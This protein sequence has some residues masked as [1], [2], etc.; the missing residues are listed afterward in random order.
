M[1]KKYEQFASLHKLM[2]ENDTVLKF[3][4]PLLSNNI[5]KRFQTMSYMAINYWQ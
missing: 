2:F 3:F 5:N 1:G 4:W